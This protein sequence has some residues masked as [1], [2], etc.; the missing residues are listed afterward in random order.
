MNEDFSRM[1]QLAGILKENQS[2]LKQD[3]LDFW[4][5]LQDDAAQSEGEYEA[6]WDTQFFIEQYPQYEGMEDQIN[7]IAS[8]IGIK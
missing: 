3:I 4:D 5:T 6:E 7:D 1:Q 8:S 2:T